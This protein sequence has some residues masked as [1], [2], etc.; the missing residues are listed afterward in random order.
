MF[1]YPSLAVAISTFTFYYLF[2][3]IT[4]LSFYMPL[5][6]FLKF[7]FGDGGRMGTDEEWGLTVNGCGISVVK[8]PHGARLGAES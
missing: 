5:F 3:H 8:A 6:L 4:F 1:S 2:P 7:M